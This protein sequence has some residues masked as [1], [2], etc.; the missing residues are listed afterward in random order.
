MSVD[1]EEIIELLGKYSV[2]QYDE[3]LA[4]IVLELNEYYG[5]QFD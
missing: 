2:S 4:S 5:T 1:Y 3:K